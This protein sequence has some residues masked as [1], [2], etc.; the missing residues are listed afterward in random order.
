M[1]TDD[2]LLEASIWHSNLHAMP[3]M[4]YPNASAPS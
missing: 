3:A 4:S 2:F 1:E